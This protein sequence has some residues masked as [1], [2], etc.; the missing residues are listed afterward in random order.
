MHPFYTH[1][2]VFLIAFLS[3]G[4]VEAHSGFLGAWNAVASGV[5]STVKSQLAAHPGY[6]IV[7][8]GH[9]LGGAL[10]S[11]AAIS[12]ASNFPSS[13]ARMYTYGQP[14]TGNP[15]YASW[16]NGVF[17][18][19]AFRGTHTSDGVPTIIPTYY[20]YQH[21]GIEYWQNPDPSTAANT[22]ACS[23]DGEDITCSAS[24]LSEGI[25][26]AHLTVSAPSYL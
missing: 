1:D 18:A 4:G 23:A 20:G 21:H 11:L 10:S 9:S 22:K 19:N 13:S 8:S 15:A 12:L 2:T 17:G 24:I 16:V 6:A 3:T 26:A 25:N 5:I 7:T 14:R